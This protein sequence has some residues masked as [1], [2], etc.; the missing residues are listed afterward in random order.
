MIPLTYRHSLWTVLCVLASTITALSQTISDDDHIKRIKKN[1]LSMQS[2]LR[3]AVVNP[4]SDFRRAVTDV[5]APNVGY[6]VDLHL[7]YRLPESPIWLVGGIT[8]T[9]LGGTYVSVPFD[10]GVFSR[11][12]ISSQT[13]L[14]PLTLGFRVQP[15]GASTFYPYA[16]AVGG[17]TALSSTATYRESRS[18]RSSERRETR[19]DGTWSYGLGLGVALNVADI[20]HL[21]NS[22]QRFTIDA[23]VRYLWG[24]PLDVVRGVVDA[25]TTDFAWQQTT[26]SNMVV[27]ALGLSLQ[28]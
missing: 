27:G 24:G 11:R 6:G 14:I 19:F 13:M 15:D 22:L 21:P 16:E 7:G 4:Q 18:N 5:G 23:S 3:F 12:E 25:T 28:F 2:G 8:P 9:F 20:V 10:G 1:E 17:I 26:K